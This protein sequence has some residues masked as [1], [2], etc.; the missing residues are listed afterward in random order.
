MNYPYG[1]PPINKDYRSFWEIDLMILRLN[2]STP[3]GIV[4][5]GKRWSVICAAASEESQNRQ[6]S[7]ESIFS[8]LLT[9]S[10]SFLGL[11]GFVM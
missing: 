3:D 1:S 6:F 10:I 2:L 7:T 5:R 11:N 8:T 9:L 4:E